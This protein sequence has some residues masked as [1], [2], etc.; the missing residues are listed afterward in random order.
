MN[1]F[2]F[3]GLY[4]KYA[5]DVFRFALYLSGHRADAEEIA[6]ETFVRAWIAPG[7]I[8]MATVKAYLFSIARHLYI[9]RWR[10]RARLGQMPADVPDAAPGPHAAAAGRDAL[11]AVM[12]ALQGMPEVDRAAVLMRADDM[13][14]EDIARALDLS[15][16]AARVRVHRARM[17]LS[18]QGLGGKG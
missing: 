18:A 7:D 13:P 8:R 2:D 11:D 5:A 14:Y 3:G 15:P 16:A 17:R 10:D 4:E 6:S 1:A 9:A 12:R